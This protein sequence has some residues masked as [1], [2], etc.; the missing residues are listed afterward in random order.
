[1]TSSRPSAAH[2]A[3]RRLDAALDNLAVAFRGMTARRDE[4]NCE[5]HWGSAEDLAL[6][7]VPDIELDDDLLQRTWRAS[8]WSDHAAVLRRILPQFARS[9]VA[10]RVEP[11]LGPEEIGRSFD[12]G[13]WQQ[14]PGEQAAAVRE[15]LHAWWTHT[16]TDPHPHRPGPGRPGPRTPRPARRGIRRAHPVA[17]PLGDADRHPGHPAPHRGRRPLGV[18]PPRRRTPLGRLAQRGRRGREARRADGLAA[19]PRPAPPH[20]PRRT[21]RT[22]PPH[23]PARPHRPGPLGG[24]VL[25]QPPLLTDRPQRRTPASPATSRLVNPAR[26]SRSYAAVTLSGTGSATMK[27]WPG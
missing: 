3:R 14:W 5:C 12:R 22:A 11:F 2:P 6:L 16:L 21:R 19:G 27:P 26:H 7:K 15:F 13:H 25:A 17:R 9:L 8:D 4:N 18:P 23:T 24:P 20:R 10:G 1:M